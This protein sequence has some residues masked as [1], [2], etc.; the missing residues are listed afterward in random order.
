MGEL[1]KAIVS[2]IFDLFLSDISSGGQ[3]FA[4]K[5]VSRI[6]L[7]KWKKELK[8]WIKEY[9]D[10]HDGTVLT[11]GRFAHYVKYHKPIEEIYR[12]ACSTE[13]S[14][15]NDSFISGLLERTKETIE[16]GLNVND[17][18]EIKHLYKE[19]LVKSI[20]MRKEMLSDNEKVIFR[21]ISHSENNILDTVSKKHDDI[22][23][24]I[25]NLRVG[26]I[27]EK[28]AIELYKN[29]NCHFWNCEFDELA[30]IC[31]VIEGKSKDL[32]L[33]IKLTLSL[34]LSNAP[35]KINH[36][37]Y[38]NI[39]CPEIRD[40]IVRKM[41]IIAYL[42]N[43]LGAFD[44]VP[45]S[46]DLKKIISEVSGGNYSSIYTETHEKKRNLLCVGL[47]I[48]DN[49]NDEMWFV[50]DIMLVHLSNL[51]YASIS[52]VMKEIT[53][54]KADFLNSLILFRQ[55]VSEGYEDKN[56][57]RDS[58]F[59][60]L[61][62]KKEYYC[63]MIPSI[64]AIFYGSYILYALQK[65]D[66]ETLCRILNEIPDTIRNN[67]SVVDYIYLAQ[68]D[69]GTANHDEIASRCEKIGKNWLLHEFYMSLESPMKV[70]DCARKQESLVLKDIM[71]YVD[72][73]RALHFVGEIEQR[74]TYLE[75]YKD[76]YKDFFEYW[77]TR[78]ELL[79]LP[80]DV[81]YLEQLWKAGAT[82]SYITRVDAMAAEIFYK[83]GKH[84]TCIDAALN[85][86][87]KGF[88]DTSVKQ[89]MIASLL[90][91][92]KR[93]E[94]YRELS[95][96]FL[97]GDRS[98]F[99][100]NNLLGL[101]L[102]LNRQVTPGLMEYVRS[103]RNPISLA[104]SAQI[105]EREGLKEE[106]REWYRKALVYSD[107][108][109]AKICGNYWNYTVQNL[110]DVQRDVKCVDIDTAILLKNVDNGGVKTICVCDKRFIPEDYYLWN[111][112]IHFSVDK[113]VQYNL[114]RKRTG[115]VI[116]FEGAQ[117]KVEEILP[118]E[119]FYDRYCLGKMIESR[120]VK[121]LTGPI[122]DDDKTNILNLT[123][124]LKENLCDNDE[125]A[126]KLIKEYGDS[127]KT[128]LPLFALSKYSPIS[129]AHFVKCIVE[130]KDIIIRE[131]YDF[132]LEET[133]DNNSGYV[134]SFSTV[135][136]CLLL[137]ISAEKL[138]ENKIYIPKSAYIEAQKENERTK[139]DNNRESV[140]Y[141]GL[142]DGRLSITQIEE[143]E[144]ASRMKFAVDLLNYCKGI[145]QID[146]SDTI[147]IDVIPEEDIMSLYGVVDYDAISICKNKGFVLVSIEQFIT[148]LAKMPGIEI[149]SITPL[150]LF[151]SLSLEIMERFILMKKMVTL[152][153]INVLNA[154]TLLEVSRLKS[155]LDSEIISCW[156]EFLNEVDKS[157]GDYRD[158]L[159]T[160]FTYISRR[161]LEEIGE[162]FSPG[163]RVFMGLTM[164][165][166]SLKFAHKINEKGELLVGIIQ[167]PYEDV[168]ST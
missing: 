125:T 2:K 19:I 131:S 43:N 132:N 92:G 16:G 121:T 118:I 22:I 63:K 155:D 114:L 93:I 57:E 102:E 38:L 113:A 6:K 162:V 145:P 1:S 50:R 116:V 158:L 159:Q 10:R 59:S 31:P 130:S 28:D 67:E 65:G 18:L 71:T 45:Y 68:I 21:Q 129:Y 41:F 79:H 100:V 157:R 5:I 25:E 109:D 111:G 7:S 64:C 168:E 103:K 124:W 104:L 136:L 4:K 51:P 34:F 33:W 81:D 46:E 37:E 35:Y 53:G 146:N 73:V 52:G 39:Q 94:A 90:Q 3:K 152:R 110:G 83:C 27:S 160:E 32:E 70:V 29:L 150:T 161:S 98:S 107:G 84:A 42:E 148:E 80:E 75:K 8:S 44:A 143:S 89:Y 123:T 149:K 141:M 126:G 23:K 106:A 147:S 48:N 17:E 88:I 62:S 26:E 134:L 142:M 60:V 139:T 122:S 137:G 167:E 78:I 105:S 15:S 30:Y 127:S 69:L 97:I 153:M 96:S 54:E 135:V 24:Q 164:K 47:K 163:I 66:K 20:E 72:Y 9:L 11:E 76:E 77:S 85:C 91:L 112:I 13:L 87:D 151:Q 120:S 144:K 140:T 36:S 117:Y 95:D 55:I 108:L 115:E 12:F 101:T 82:K 166:N 86:K 58:M 99:I 128:P 133:C 56:D 156:I 61:E 74:D 40:D 138:A 165:L 154:S 49:S 119:A 14:N